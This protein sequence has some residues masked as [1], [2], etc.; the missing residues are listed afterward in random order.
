MGKIFGPLLTLVLIAGVGFAIY[1]SVREKAE[2]S[3]TKSVRG[4]IGSEKEDFFRDPRVI[5]ALKKHGLEVT[6]EKAGSR[7]I[8]NGFDLKKY[9][10][11]FPSGYPAA[12]KIR[13]SLGSAK[14]FDEFYTPMAIASWK[15]IAELLAAE[16]YAKDKGGYYSLDFS[17]LFKAMSAGRR[18]KDLRGNSAYPVNKRILITSTDIR[19][20]NSAAMYLSLASYVA[21]GNGVIQSDSE[22]A[23]VLPQVEALFLNQGFSEYSSE[24]PF[25]DYLVMGMGK[26]PMVMIYEAQF[27]SRAARADGGI[28]KDMVLMYPEPT[29]FSKHI[30]VA[31]TPAGEKLGDLLQK[32]PDLQK[33]AVEFGFR[34]SDPHRFDAFTAAHGFKVP[35]PIVDVAE[36]PSFGAL[37]KMIGEIEKKYQ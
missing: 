26:S 24:T 30:L 5:S 34:T 25:E 37:E 6:V 22:A 12:E 32:D 9:D 21:N 27:L 4:L 20:S 1:K 35:N 11:A 15:A 18:W 29:V 36:P 10:F 16:G 19:K 2:A 13:Q 33:L 3:A 17:A 23:R 8:A 28:S 7:Q 14:S 31:V